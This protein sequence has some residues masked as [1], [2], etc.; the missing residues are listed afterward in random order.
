[1]KTDRALQ[2][3]GAWCLKT[4]R[5]AVVEVGD[6]LDDL[7]EEH[8][9]FLCNHQST[10]DVPML[11]TM[12]AARGTTANH[13]FWI[14][15]AIFRWTHFGMVS[16]CRGDFFVECVSSGRGWNW[17]TGARRSSFAA[18]NLSEL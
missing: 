17:R 5:T 18:L 9:L 14:M 8:C 6:S 15:D 10:A 1:M 4:D 13:V 3:C 2:V 16:Q 12:L 7:E 11:M